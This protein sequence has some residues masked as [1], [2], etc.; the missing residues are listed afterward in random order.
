[1]TSPSVRGAICYEAETNF[2]ED[3]T[4]FATLRVPITTPVDASGLK[5]DKI[6][7]TRTQQTRQGGSQWILGNQGGTFKTRL[8]L[9]GHG[10]ATSGSITAGLTETLIGHAIGNVVVSAASG[11]TA[12]GGTSNIPTTTASGGFLAGSLTRFG[13]FGDGRG[14]GQYAAIHDHTG[15][16]M[17]LL[18]NVDVAPNAADVIYAATMMYPSEDAT[19]TGTTI[20]GLRFLLQTATL[21]YECHGVVATGW[22]FA[23]FKAGEIPYIEIT[24]SVSWWRYSTATFPSPVATEAFQPAANANGSLFVNDVG[25]ATRAAAN[26]RVYRDLTIDYKAG[27]ELLPG[28]GGAGPYQ[29]IVNACRTIDAITVSWVED[30]DPQTATPVLPGFGTGTTA[31]HILLTLN[32]TATKSVGFYMP[33]VCINNVAVQYADG[34]VQRLKVTGMAYT[35]PTTTTDLTASAFRMAWS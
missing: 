16:N 17:T 7:S 20:G 25:T 31:K 3:V 9:T 35:G 29:S 4:T 18:T 32:P 13:V 33:N 2:G 28:P 27:V 14:G 19:A 23:G 24:W 21:E 22:T 26:K 34:N 1:M 6:D 30:A 15:H 12:T 10:S 5:H 8:Q 11:D